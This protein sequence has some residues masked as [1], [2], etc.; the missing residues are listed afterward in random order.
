MKACTVFPGTRTSREVKRLYR[1]AFL[2][3]ERCPFLRLLLL[4]I[5]SANV[6]L[7]GYWR[8]REFCGFTLSVCSDK[9]LYINYIAV[10]PELR[11]EG[12]GTAI[13]RLLAGANPEKAMLV[14]VLSPPEGS[15][16]WEQRN[17][18][19][20]FYRR[21]GFFD[22]GRTI[23]GKGGDYVLLSTDAVYDREAYWRIFDHMSFKSF[24]R[25]REF[26]KD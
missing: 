2:P 10:S 21:N 24:F 16:G 11:S 18:R 15:D 19:M 5:F 13:L 25:F 6:S 17:R 12:V 23:S 8:E 9:Y 3:E 22:L 7:R 20:A 26:K 14:E 4:N 1:E